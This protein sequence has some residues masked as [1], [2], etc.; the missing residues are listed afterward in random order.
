MDESYIE[1]VLSTVER[2][3]PGK[4]ATY[5]DIAELIGLGGPRQVG[6]V[7][8]LHGGAVPWWRVVRSNGR[9]VRGIEAR[10]LD[11]L[12]RDGTPLRDDRVDLGVAR[13]RPG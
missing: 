4:V 2:I 3:P 11:L 12:R 13:Y 1:L 8:S 9:P 6:R 7:M 10:A 5:G